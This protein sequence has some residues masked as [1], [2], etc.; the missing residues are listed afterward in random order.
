MITVKELKQLL[1]KLPDHAE[2]YAYEGEATGI[3][4]IDKKTGKM[5]WISAYERGIDIYTEGF[6]T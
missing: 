4:V 1:E 5:W 6:D 2:V 3:N